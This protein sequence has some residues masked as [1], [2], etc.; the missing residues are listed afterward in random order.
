[1]V[2]LSL[3]PALNNISLNNTCLCFKS[4]AFQQQVQ[5]LNFFFFIFIKLQ[6][7]PLLS[8]IEISCNRS[9]KNST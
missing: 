6:L 1:M 8:V 4:S 7:Y 5:T 9:I 2:I 3:A